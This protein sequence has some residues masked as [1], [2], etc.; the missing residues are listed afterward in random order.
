MPDAKQRYDFPTRGFLTKAERWLY[1]GPSSRSIAT[2]R[3]R[4]SRR[5]LPRSPIFHVRSDTTDEGLD[6][7]RPS[8]CRVDPWTRVVSVLTLGDRLEP[9]AKLGGVAGECGLQHVQHRLTPGRG[10]DRES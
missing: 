2:P 9:G 4:S 10:L 8:A 5:S 1:P 7:P 6:R 3:S